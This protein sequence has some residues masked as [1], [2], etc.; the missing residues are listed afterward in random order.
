MHHARRERVP[1]IEPARFP[2]GGVGHG[3]G[4]VVADEQ[5]E[6]TVAVV[7]DEGGAISVAP[8]AG[9]GGLRDVAENSP[10]QVLEEAVLLGPHHD[11]E[12]GISVIVDVAEHRGHRRALRIPHAR[13]RFFGDVLEGTVAPVT[14]QVIRIAP[15]ALRDVQV[16]QAIAVHVRG[17]D[18][19]A[20]GRE[21][22]HD[23]VQF[24]RE[25]AERVNVVKARLRRA[26]FESKVRGDAR[27]ASGPQRVR[28][29]GEEHPHDPDA[30]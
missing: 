20:D 18:R 29:S 10:A 16:D 23:V 7:I 19:R 17:G 27:P 12:I 2:G 5:V 15:A 13:A 6:Q 24:S 11:V 8:K 14:E 25:P 21:P 22:R 3:L 1:Q 26:L 9:A 30:Q 28:T 4:E